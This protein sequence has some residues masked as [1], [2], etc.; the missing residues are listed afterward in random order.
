MARSYSIT[1]SLLGKDCGSDKNHFNSAAEGLEYLA[2]LKEG[3]DG[4]AATSPEELICWCIQY[5]ASRERTLRKHRAKVDLI[6]AVLKGEKKAPKAGLPKLK[7][8][9][10]SVINPEVSADGTSPE[11]VAYVA[12]APERSKVKAA[13]PERWEKGEAS[14]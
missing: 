1:P 4:E 14:K 10:P 11:V 2:A 12:K 6:E 7:R 8:Y 3:E 5:A 9:L 13:P